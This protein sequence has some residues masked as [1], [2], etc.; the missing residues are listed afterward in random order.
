MRSAQ[1]KRRRVARVYLCHKLALHIWIQFLE[2][3]ASVF[4]P[5]TSQMLIL[6]KEVDAQV[7]FANNGRVL[8]GKVADSRQNEVLESLEPDHT[9][10]RVDEEDVR[11]LER[12]LTRSS[13][14][15]QLTIVPSLFSSRLRGD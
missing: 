6:E 3:I 11:L 9:W 4:R 13:P 12:Y 15:T 2:Q 8:Y 14:E 1:T 7:G 5:E 10:A